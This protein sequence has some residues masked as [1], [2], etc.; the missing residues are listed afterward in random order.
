MIVRFPLTAVLALATFGLVLW[1][2]SWV[3]YWCV[4]WLVG[5]VRRNSSNVS[6]P[7]PT[8]ATCGCTDPRF[9]ALNESGCAPQTWHV[10]HPTR[11]EGVA[12]AARLATCNVSCACAGW[13]VLDSDPEA[14][15]DG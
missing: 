14:L 10:D 5:A 11:S 4:G 2:L 8:P 3:S 7:V 9:A 1:L 12:D 15:R 6:R 13:C